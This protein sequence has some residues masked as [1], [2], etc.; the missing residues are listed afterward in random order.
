MRKTVSQTD[1][2]EIRKIWQGIYWWMNKRGLTPK[3]L[4]HRT[5]YRQDRLERGI[6]G[7]PEPI[8]HALRDFAYALNLPSG[9][10]GRFYEETIE[11]LSDA[12]LVEIITSPVRP[13][14]GKLWDE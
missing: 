9:R 10:E 2:E 13:R 7:E 5:K 4:A 14:Q 12:E 8:R 6:R 11:T 1:I 3:E